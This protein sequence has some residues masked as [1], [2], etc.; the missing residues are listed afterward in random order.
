M[1]RGR[2]EEASCDFNFLISCCISVSVDKETYCLE[3]SNSE[4]GDHESFTRRQF[5]S[6]IVN[7]REDFGSKIERNVGHWR[8]SRDEGRRG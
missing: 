8:Y 4:P 2:R 1:R 6:E 3:P 5:G 7:C